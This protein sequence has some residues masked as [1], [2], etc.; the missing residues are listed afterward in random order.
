MPRLSKFGYGDN[1]AGDGG[2]LAITR[3]AV[4]LPHLVELEIADNDVSPE[5]L[6][7]LARLAGGRTALDAQF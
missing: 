1:D 6:D 7:A 2:A 4:E 3:A 5:G